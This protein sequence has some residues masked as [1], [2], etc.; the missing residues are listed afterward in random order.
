[1][2]SAFLCFSKVST[3]CLLTLALSRDNLSRQRC[4]FYPVTSDKEHEHVKA[5]SQASGLQ[6]VLT[7]LPARQRRRARWSDFHSHIYHHAYNNVY[8]NSVHKCQY[9]ELENF[10][11]NDSLGMSGQWELSSRNI[12]N[13]PKFNMLTPAK[14]LMSIM[15]VPR[16]TTIDEVDDGT[17]YRY[18]AIRLKSFEKWPLSY[19]KPESLV[20]AG[21]YFTGELDIVRCFE[22]GTEMYKWL[23]GD[24]PMVDHERQSPTCK[25][26]RNAFCD[27]VSFD[28]APDIS[29]ASPMTEDRDVCGPYECDLPPDY[30]KLYPTNSSCAKYPEYK[31]YEAR[32]R[33]FEHWPTF[34]KQ[35]PEELSLAGFYYTGEKDQVLCFH[36]GVG[37]KHWEPNDDPWEQH[38][39]WYPNCYYLHEVKG[40]RYVGKVTG[41][42]ISPKNL[43]T[44]SYVAKVELSIDAESET[45]HGKFDEEN[46]LPGSPGPS[47]QGND[48]SGVESISSNN[49]SIKDSN[50]NL[51]DAEAGC[52]KSLSDS[53]ICKICFDGEISQLF[54]SCGHLLTCADCAK[55]IKICP[56]CRTFITKQ[57]KVIF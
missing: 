23:E 52:S 4:L 18:E 55:C 28:V 44:A 49:S 10:C 31:L 40:S 50:E 15:N 12:L 14:L 56:V 43:Q 3:E 34:L 24:D 57:M 35:S 8:N 25:F 41:Q 22:C 11:C 54:L 17:D 9:L 53:R 46:Y 19:M 5:F 29:I 42:S 45:E 32:L 26:I 27:N 7:L 39:M 6:W 16:D 20:A 47:S 33:T 13:L 2:T 30:Y 51:F 21:F 48:D 36:C 38:A 37:V 1:M